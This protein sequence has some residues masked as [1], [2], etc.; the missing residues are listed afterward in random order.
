LLISHFYHLE[1]TQSYSAKHRRKTLVCSCRITWR[2]NVRRYGLSLFLADDSGD[3]IMKTTVALLIV[4]GTGAQLALAQSSGP[5]Y[6]FTSGGGNGMRSEA[7]MEMRQ[8]SEAA[9]IAVSV[10][11][12]I[13]GDVTYLCGG[14]GEQEAAYMKQQAKGY[15]LMLTFA[16]RDG[17]YLADV[18]VDIRNAQGQQVLSANCDAPIMLV[19]LPQSGRYHVRANTAGYALDRTVRVNAKQGSQVAAAV[20]SWPQQVAEAESRSVTSSGGSTVDSGGGRYRSGTR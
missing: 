12:Q 1:K 19:D 5:G 11:P 13:E 7:G 20:M 10:Q 17:A 3:F 9:A 18:D 14:I 6:E 8:E 16:A 4:L 15:D 2:G